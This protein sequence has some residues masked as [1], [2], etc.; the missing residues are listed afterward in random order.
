MIVAMTVGSGID[1]T[2]GGREERKEEGNA[3]GMYNVWGMPLRGKGM[4][5]QGTQWKWGRQ[6]GGEA[7]R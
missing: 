1:K 3:W 7:G 6:V 2:Q 4:R 5:L